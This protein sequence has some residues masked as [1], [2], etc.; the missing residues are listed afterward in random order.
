MFRSKSLA[1]SDH[2]GF[3]D[4]AEVDPCEMHNWPRGDIVGGEYLARAV[5]GVV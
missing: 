5:I 2:L 1:V 4:F 3:E